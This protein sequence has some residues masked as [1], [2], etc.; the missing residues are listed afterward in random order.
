MLFARWGCHRWLRALCDPHSQ[1]LVR[2]GENTDPANTKQENTH[3]D[4]CSRVGKTFG[5]ILVLPKPGGNTEYFNTANTEH[6]HTDPVCKYSLT[7]T[8]RCR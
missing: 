8:N 7:I 6:L 2:I 3:T 4:H 5:K 1:Y